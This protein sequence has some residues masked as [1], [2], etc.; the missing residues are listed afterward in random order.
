MKGSTPRFAIATT[1]LTLSLSGCNQDLED[2]LDRLEAELRGIRSDTRDEVNSLKERVIS[3]E[4]KVGVSDDG[5]SLDQRVDLIEDSL[6]EAISSK[7]ADNNMVYLRPLLQ[8]H[9]PLPTDH[10]TFLV[11]IEGMDLNVESSGF[12]V[13]LNIGNPH[14]LAI[15]Q[16]TLKG[17][18]GGGTPELLEDDDYS[19]DNPAIIAW[20]KTL[21]PFE[22][23]VSK[24]LEPFSWTPFDIVL[25]A[26][27]RE[28]LELI[29]FEM[30]IEN[31]QLNRPGGMG[32]D[33]SNQFS[34]ISVDSK[35]ASVLKTEYG[36]FLIVIKN[37]VEDENGTKL[38]IEIGNPYGFTINQCRLLGDF[39]TAL[40]KRE[41]S[42]SNED[43]S[44][45]MQAWSASLQPFESLVSDKI[46]NFRWNKATIRVPAPANQVKFLRAQLRV[47]DVTL[48]AATEK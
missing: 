24:T 6:S 33:S 26:D 7:S 8:G 11:R 5:T 48:P 39:G 28:E 16:F 47:E 23:R 30:I 1:A 35:A 46:S 42:P 3:A 27:A 41:D 9:A 15:Q 19:P 37:A 13:H 20:Q 25:E 12:T 29:R 43:Y 32:G 40:P 31:A 36:A 4:T 38:D 14:A 21:K 44:E 45:K 2:R 10:G 34:H 17:D 18:H 22:Y